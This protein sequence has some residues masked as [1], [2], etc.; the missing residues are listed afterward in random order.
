MNSY[1]RV[2]TALNREEPDRVPTFE[3]LIDQAVIAGMCG[4]NCP[5]EDFVE[6]MD[7]DGIVVTAVNKH[8]IIGDKHFIDEWGIEK[9]SVHTDPLPM[10]IRGPLSNERDLK[11]YVIPNPH[12]PY[13]MD[14][15]RET[16]KRYKG[17]KAI[18]FQV[19]DG[20]S[21]ARDLLGFEKVLTGMLDSP[22]LVRDLVEISTEYYLK[23]A[24]WAIDEGADIIFSGDDLADNRGPLFNPRLFEEIFFP[25]FKRL[26]G[27]VKDAGAY[28]IKHT[29]GN[30]W[31][32]IPYFIDAGIDCLDPI[33]KPASMD[34]RKVKKEYGKYLAVKGNID[35]RYTLTQGT[36]DDVKAEV[37]RCIAEASPGGGHI[38]SSSNSIHSGVNTQNYTAMLDAIR[39]YG[40]Y[41]I[42]E[43]LAND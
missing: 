37:R 34:M 25:G 4:S 9:K 29:D 35:C 20:F 13:R 5:L 30:I 11:S 16:V 32:L 6:K 22:A 23:L 39:E 15:L 8:K 17:K 27:G 21:T 42:N 41:P 18:I 36:A 24:A 38:I 1:E 7:I 10:A 12:A 2:M 26:V 3:W 33:E 19:R 28:Y 31:D 40:K 43:N 14:K